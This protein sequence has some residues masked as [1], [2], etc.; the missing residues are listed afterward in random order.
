MKSILDPAF[1]YVPSNETDLR[2]TFARVYRQQKDAARLDSCEGGRNSTVAV[3]DKQK[4]S[5]V[6]PCMPAGR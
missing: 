1:R 3:N 2:K 6:I 5:A 4:Q